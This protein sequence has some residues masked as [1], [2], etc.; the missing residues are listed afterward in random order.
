MNNLTK[1]E[2]RELKYQALMEESRGISNCYTYANT[3]RDEVDKAFT[4]LKESIIE[5]IYQY[6][7]SGEDKLLIYKIVLSEFPTKLRPVV[8]SRL[9]KDKIYYDSLHEAILNGPSSLIINMGGVYELVP[10]I[11]FNTS[12]PIEL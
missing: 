7:G 2:I 3:L 8:V 11:K 1:Q 5:K 4:Q 9:T 12:T 10:G 6:P